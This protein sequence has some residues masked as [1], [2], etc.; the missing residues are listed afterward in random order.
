[1][2]VKEKAYKVARKD[3]RESK[4][5]P[6]PTVLHTGLKK[7]CLE[8]DLLP[9]QE[10]PAAKA[11]RLL[12]RALSIKKEPVEVITIVDDPPTNAP[13]HCVAVEFARQRQI[14][15]KQQR[16]DE[17]LYLLISRVFWFVVCVTVNNA[18][19]L[20]FF[21]PVP[22]YQPLVSNHVV[23]VYVFDF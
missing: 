23:L 18:S 14:K 10:S 19:V 16:R 17:K 11:A 4:K 1:M 20:E 21:Y 8:G 12:L 22:I 6:A 9:K 5:R 7:A 2:A 13:S 3:F 15:A